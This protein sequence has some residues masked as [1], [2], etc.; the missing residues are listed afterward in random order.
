MADPIPDEVAASYPGYVDPFGYPELPIE[1]RL[2]LAANPDLD[3]TAVQGWHREDGDG[4][5]EEI[6]GLLA[7]HDWRTEIAIANT[8]GLVGDWGTDDVNEA[9]TNALHE[10]RDLRAR[11][12]AQQPVIDAAQTWDAAWSPGLVAR[13]AGGA[14]HDALS[15]YEAALSGSVEADT[16]AG[17]KLVAEAGIEPAPALPPAALPGPG[18]PGRGSHCATP[19]AADD[20]GNDEKEVDT[21]AEPALTA[22]R[23]VNAECGDCGHTSGYHPHGGPCLRG[24]PE[25]AGLCPCARFV[26]QPAREV[27]GTP[28]AEPAPAPDRCD[29]YVQTTSACPPIIKTRELTDGINIDYDEPSGEVLGIEFVGAYSVQVNGRALAGAG[30]PTEPVDDTQEC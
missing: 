19:R 6:I 5:R 22:A 30:A 13:D 23:S 16:P 10:Y 14:L 29:V 7:D 2:F 4:C 15:D 24:R 11:L 26:D 1:K 8:M 3:E 21:P 27:A 18:V 28:A 25:D 17:E 9:V 20:T 12:A